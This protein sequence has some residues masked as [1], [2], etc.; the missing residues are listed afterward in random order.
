M[1]SLCIKKTQIICLLSNPSDYIT[2]NISI[3]LE[4]ISRL[5]IILITQLTIIRNPLADR[6]SDY[7]KIFSVNLGTIF[8][9]IRTPNLLTIIVLRNK[10]W[11]SF[12]ETNDDWQTQGVEVSRFLGFSNSC[13]PRNLGTLKPWNLKKFHS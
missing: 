1:A 12:Y 5:I 6:S 9:F 8:R 3:H 10:R 11:L 7:I 2:T 13:F 4:T